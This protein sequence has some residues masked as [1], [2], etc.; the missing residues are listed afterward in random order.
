MRAATRA[1]EG[2]R[3]PLDVKVL[4]AL[5]PR[6][7]SRAF[8]NPRF[9]VVPLGPGRAQGRRTTDSSREGRNATLAAS[10][11][12]GHGE[13]EASQTHAQSG[14]S[15]AAGLAPPTPEAG[16]CGL[17]SALRAPPPARRGQPRAG[18]WPAEPGRERL[19]TLR[20]G[21]ARGRWPQER[22]PRG[23]GSDAARG[24]KWKSCRRPEASW[25]SCAR[26]RRWGARAVAC[27]RSCWRSTRCAG[28]R[29]RGV[30]ARAALGSRVWG[31]GSR[32]RRQSGRGLREA[33]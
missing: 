30:C 18:S 9:Q 7:E 19:G 26:G 33:R 31:A 10:S 21:R 20:R 22:L 4:A 32:G 25:L 12:P 11:W 13:A 3:Q 14:R 27:P 28:R 29:S 6:S 1:A 15:H 8:R 5:R 16:P 2:E 24:R 17:G 23:R